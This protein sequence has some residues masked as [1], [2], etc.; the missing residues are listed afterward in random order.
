MSTE[1]SCQKCES[2]YQLR[3][4]SIN[5]RDKDFISCDVCGYKLYSWSE[6]KIWEATLLK[7]SNKHLNE[8]EC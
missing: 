5:F 8:G 6:A 2:I 1:I 3:Y 7:K 4:T